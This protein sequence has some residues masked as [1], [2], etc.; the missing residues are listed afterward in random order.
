M[1]TCRTATVARRRVKGS[2]PAWIALCALAAAFVGCGEAGTAALSDAGLREAGETQVNAGTDRVDAGDRPVV[3]QLS[4]VVEDTRGRRIE[5]AKVALGGARSVTNI[6]G[7]FLLDSLEPSTNALLTVSLTGYSTGKVP[8]QI[9]HGRNHVRVSL[10]QAQMA[11]LQTPG[12]GGEVKLASGGSITLPADALVDANGESVTDPVQ[13]V[14]AVINDRDEMRAAPGGMLAID[15]NASED[16]PATQLESFGMMQVSLS[17]N[18]KPVNLREEVTAWL[19]FPLAPHHPFALGDSVELWSFGDEET[20]WRSEGT[21]TVVEGNKLQ[22]EVGH[23]SWW[24]ADA[25]LEKTCVTGRVLDAAGKAVPAAQLSVEGRSYLGNARATSDGDGQFCFEARV[26]SAIQVRALV[27]AGSGDQL[28]AVQLNTPRTAATCAAPSECLALPQ[29]WV[30]TPVDANNRCAPSECP[31]D[32]SG[33]ERCCMS[34]IGPCSF[35]VNGDCGG[36]EDG[37]WDLAPREPSVQ[38]T[39]SEVDDADGGADDAG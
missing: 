25:L 13:V 5:A 21:G 9:L 16:A 32:P 8:L 1:A 23:F 37:A 35:V 38:D 39:P 20:V 24:N 31:F 28:L 34:E 12:E 3:T 4:G 27:H 18:G 26:A 2:S 14:F 11:I 36:R 17:A 33:K 30:T 10:E 19:E 29:A 7:E 6:D 15:P 22:A